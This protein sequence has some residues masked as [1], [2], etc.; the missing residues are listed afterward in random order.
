MHELADQALR[1]L[2]IE[3]TGQSE[4]SNV[5]SMILASIKAIRKF[6]DWSAT[7]APATD[8]VVDV[9]PA[10][11]LKAREKMLTQETRTSRMN[12]SYTINLN[13]PATY[14]SS[15][16]NAIFKSLRENL[17]RDSDD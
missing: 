3:E 15:V 2:I 1:G 17:L 11:I 8:K 12:L 10:P 5:V 7:N 16:F 9:I 6:A 4:D 13:L 14:D